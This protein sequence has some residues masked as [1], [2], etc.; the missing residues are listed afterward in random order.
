MLI[1]IHYKETNLRVHLIIVYIYIYIYIIVF[2]CVV[3]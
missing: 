3:I 1:I 2:K